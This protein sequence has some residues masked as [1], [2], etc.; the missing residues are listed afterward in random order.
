MLAAKAVTHT[1]WKSDV[2]QADDTAPH[3]GVIFVSIDEN[4][5]ANAGDMSERRDIE[6]RKKAADE[7]PKT[8]EVS[9]GSRATIAHQVA[10]REGLRQ[11]DS[12]RSNVR[13]LTHENDALKSELAE[14]RAKLDTA[15]Q[16]LVDENAALR[17]DLEE[18]GDFF[19]DRLSVSSDIEAAIHGGRGRLASGDEAPR[20]RMDELL[21]ENAELR[22]DLADARAWFE[23]YTAKAEK[24]L[25]HHETQCASFGKLAEEKN[26]LRGELEQMRSELV[27]TKAEL[28]NSKA[29]LESQ[30][31]EHARFLVKFLESY[32]RPDQEERSVQADLK[33]VK[34]ET[35][36]LMPRSRCVSPDVRCRILGDAAL[37]IADLGSSVSLSS[38]RSRLPGTPQ[39]LLS[40]PKTEALGSVTSTDTGPHL[41][42]PESVSRRAQSAQHNRR[43]SQSSVQHAPAFR[44]R[45]A[46]FGSPSP[47]SIGYSTGASGSLTLARCRP[48]Q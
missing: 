42:T 2:P 13:Q 12:L 19:V 31:F 8:R 11:Q 16:E 23:D 41:A 29:E 32:S 15:L 21:E 5:S 46:A 1:T 27:G 14:A 45:H 10:L 47:R 9:P 18:R 7:V 39:R 30:R 36:P 38:P 33:P 44:H 28:A 17:A 43:A 35:L 22:A 3:A 25:R 24:T 4:T 26:A 34:C 20:S 37:P 6:A 48:R 40:S